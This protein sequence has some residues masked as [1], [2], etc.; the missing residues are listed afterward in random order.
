MDDL[1][2]LEHWL[3]PLTRQLGPQAQKRLGRTISIELRKDNIRN[4]RHQVG[5]DGDRWEKRKV[6]RNLAKPIRYFYKARDGH[7]REIEMSS[8]RND[9]DRIVGYDKEAGGIRT[10]LK[11]GM[12]RSLT[13]KFPAAGAWATGKKDGNTKTLKETYASEK[14]A[15]DAA[16]AERQRI[17][18]GMATF[19]LALAMGRPEITAQSPIKVS[20]W[21]EEIDGDD[22]LVKEVTHSLNDG[23]GWTSKAQMERGSRL[24]ST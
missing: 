3:S 13:A 11:K 16:K 9:G 15:L 24:T 1:D 14:D 22:W 20:G 23:S 2:H 12:L 19:E 7:E 4:I 21:K 8:Y 18:R 5:P 10:M 6:T 17:E